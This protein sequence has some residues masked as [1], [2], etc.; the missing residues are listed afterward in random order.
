MKK[1]NKT[2]IEYDNGKSPI[3]IGNL[4]TTEKELGLWRLDIEKENYKSLSKTN[5]KTNL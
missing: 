3:R 1:K 4:W 5:S 2:K